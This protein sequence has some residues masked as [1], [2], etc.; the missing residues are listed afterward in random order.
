MINE[1]GLLSLSLIGRTDVE[2]GVLVSISPS[3]YISVYARRIALNVMKILEGQNPKDFPVQ[4]SGLKEDFVINAATMEQIDIYPSFGVLSKA[5]MIAIIPKRNVHYTIESAVAHALENNLNYLTEKKNGEIQNTE[6]RIA[7]SNL[8]PNGELSSSVL[9]LDSRS[10][11]LLAAANQ[12]TPQTEWSGNFQ[13]NQVLY[14]EPANANVSIQ[15]MLLESEKQG[16][17]SLQ[18]DLVL[19]V[20]TAYLRLLQTH[21]NLNIQ[22][23]NVQTTSKNLNIVK[24]KANIGTV[25][26]A[27]VYGFESQLALNKISL[28]DA[29]TVLEQGMIS[30]NT[31]LNISLDRHLIL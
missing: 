6:I 21:A 31:L 17:L 13:V 11:Q 8:R 22:N 16:L 12:L 26:L 27:D 4:I 3:E 9:N 20:C 30:F 29:A 19:D 23:N 5:S 14:S 2:K 7:Q 10:A 24:T 15:K 1:L 18:L 25:S 28:D